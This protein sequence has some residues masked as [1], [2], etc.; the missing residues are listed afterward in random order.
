[1]APALP[2]VW[3]LAAPP[4]LGALI[5]WLTN[6][7]AVAMLFR[8]HRPINLPGLRIQGLLPRRRAEMAQSLSRVFEQRLL[9]GAQIARSLESRD[10]SEQL[11]AFIS[12][13]IRE[14]LERELKR[15]RLVQNLLPRAAIVKLA[16]AVAGQL[17]QYLQAHWEKLAKTVVAHVDVAAIVRENIESLDLEEL[18]AVTRELAHREFRHIET[19]GAVLGFLIGALQ[20]ALIVVL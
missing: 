16:D 3:Q 17:V 14:R 7:L 6:R 12:S 13:V 9:N 5:G 2:F 1:M 15:A 10:L 18:E 4:I 20:A 8:P 19:A 11:H